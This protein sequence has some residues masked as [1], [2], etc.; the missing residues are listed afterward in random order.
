VKR[1]A[2]AVCIIVSLLF[3]LKYQ[4]D[5][6]QIGTISVVLQPCQYTDK[7]NDLYLWDEIEVGLNDINSVNNNW[8]EINKTT[9]QITY[10]ADLETIKKVVKYLNNFNKQHCNNTLNN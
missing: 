1:I 8:F 6:R 3:A 2:I 7:N 10:S 9:A 4:S 5:N